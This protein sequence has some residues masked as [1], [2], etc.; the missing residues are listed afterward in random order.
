M[1]ALAD[2]MSSATRQRLRSR[3]GGAVD[4]TLLELVQ[5]IAEDTR[6]DREIV[7]TVVHLLRSGRVRLIGSFRGRRLDAA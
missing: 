3:G 7:A 4:T 2:T 6:D 1:S 5:T